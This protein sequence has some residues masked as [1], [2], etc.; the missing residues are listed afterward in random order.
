MSYELCKDEIK[1]NLVLL[2]STRH[3]SFLENGE[4]KDCQ[5]LQALRNLL[6]IL[7]LSY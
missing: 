5:C 4:L 1:N 2:L 6:A 7:R 3:F